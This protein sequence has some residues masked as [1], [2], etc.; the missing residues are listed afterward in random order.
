MSP[1]ESP[2]ENLADHARDTTVVVIGGGIAG[3][4]AALECAKVGM[5]V[6]VL[7]AQDRLGGVIRAE[8]VDGVEVP[9]GADGWAT[10]GGHVRALVDELGLTGRLSAEAAVPAWVSGIPSGSAPLPREVVLGIP[11]N[12]WDPAVRRIIGWRGVWRAYLDRLRPPLTIG[13]QSNLDKLVRGR[14]GDRVVDRLVAPLSVGRHGLSPAEVD[15]DVAAPGLNSA[16]TRTG[17]LS[18]AVAQV[19][20]SR[21]ANPPFETLD[22]GLAPVVDA[23]RERLDVLGAEVRTSTRVASLVRRGTPGWSVVTDDGDLDAD[24]VVVAASE[25]DARRLLAPHLDGLASRDAVTLDVVTLVVDGAGPQKAVFPVPGS[26]PAVSLM[27]PSARWPWLAE[28]LGPHRAIVRVT[29]ADAPA[30]DADAVEVA[31][32]AASALAAVDPHDV[33]DA[34]IDRLAT[35]HPRSAQ[36]Q[37]AE[38]ERVRAAVSVVPGLAAVGAWLSGSGLAQVIPDAAAETERVRRAALF[39][40]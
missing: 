14:M 26:S 4:V 3:L 9:V 33:R 6:T 32:A 35:T 34:R 1:S 13:Q 36:G 24:V 20:G 30:G 19:R 22:G 12:P 7:E 38:A 5:R 16:L 23:L 11:A 8:V 27:T 15:V 2:L 18:G 28:L 40:E 17:S 29:L 37:I 10:A 31:T 25:S 39:G 21:P